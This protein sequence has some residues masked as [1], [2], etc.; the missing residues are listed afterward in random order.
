MIRVALCALFFANAYQIREQG[1]AVQKVIQ[2]MQDMLAK[3]KAAKMDEEVKFAAYK[4][5]C[6]GTTAE[7]KTNIADAAAE[8]EDLQASIQKAESDAA[9]LAEDIA[10]LDEDIAGWTSDMK[11]ATAQREKEKGDFEKT[12]RDY[13]ESLDALDRALVV[14]K[15]QSADVPQAMML[16]QRVI[17]THK[18]P[19]SAKRTILA[20]LSLDQDPLS[21]TAPQAKGYEF[22]S[23]GVVEMLENLRDKFQKEK[24]DL[25][26]DEMGAKHAYDLMMLDLK[27]SI[28]SAESMRATKAKMKAGKEA[29]A[30]TDKG[31]LAD[32]TASK[33][34]DEKYLEDLVSQ[35]EQKSNDFASRQQLRAE[36]LEAI[37]KAIEIISSPDVAGNAGKHLSLAQSFALRASHK[38]KGRISPTVVAYLQG[39]ADNLQSKGLKML[40]MQVAETERE[41]ADPF[42]KVK[43][44]IDSMI[45]K[46]LEEANEESDK[47]GWCDKE[48]AVNGQTRED[49]TEEV[50][51]L[52]AE[53]DKL[54]ADIIKLSEQVADLSVAIQETDGAMVNATDIRL[55]EKEKNKNT[56]EDAKDAQTAVGQ[57][58]AVLKDFYAKAATA[59]ALVQQ[60]QTPEEEAPE[61]FDEPYTGMGGASGGVVGLL[62]VIESDFSKLEAETTAAEEEAAKEYDRFMAE[63]KKDKAVKTADMDYKK[64]T[65]T[66]KE[67]D[68]SDTTADLKG[69][70]KELQSALFYYEKLKPQCVD[71]GVS[72]EERV[73]K[74]EAEIE[75]LKTALKILSDV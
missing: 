23:G 68:L 27:D 20:Y 4:Q 30:A 32:T 34:E 58:I 39:R 74:R 29:D 42:A 16:L 62:E 70:E 56:I 55:A 38:S 67:S 69:T 40:A 60:K 1:A 31:S 51:S 17:A 18:V 37:Q 54:K 57:A 36:E 33:T 26:K 63:S 9:V 71:A 75:S 35:C 50:N 43:K 49:K 47:K 8:I 73:S 7:K 5:F 3:G 46:L 6:E 64:K 13:E 11:E 14:L 15:K 24:N 25:E 53:V 44:M 66:Q 19:Q 59:T 41:M 61:T 12:L 2:L 65:K 28:S 72:Y 10:G 52:T 45:T 21:V 48:M 22:Q